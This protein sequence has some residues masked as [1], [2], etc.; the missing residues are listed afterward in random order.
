MR[1]KCE[2]KILLSDKPFYSVI[3]AGSTCPQP[4]TDHEQA[5]HGSQHNTNEATPQPVIAPQMGNYSAGG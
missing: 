3:M 4:K 2:C 1:G 5:E